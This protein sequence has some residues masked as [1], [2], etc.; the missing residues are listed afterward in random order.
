MDCTSA[1]LPAQVPMPSATQSTMPS[2]TDTANVV[3][4]VQ[5][6]PPQ[7]TPEFLTQKLPSI[8]N[9]NPVVMTPSCSGGFSG[10]VSQNPWLAAG[11]LAVLAVMVFGHKGR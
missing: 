5:A 11:G 8:V 9:P 6:Q 3:A 7:L 4:P 2:I 10:W 1:V